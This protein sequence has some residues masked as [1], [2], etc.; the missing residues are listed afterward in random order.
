MVVELH[1][2]QWF[3]EDDFCLSHHACFLGDLE[4]VQT[5]ECSVISPPFLLVLYLELRV[6][7]G[8]GV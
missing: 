4:R 2:T 6:R 1:I 8:F 5:L 7:R 3:E